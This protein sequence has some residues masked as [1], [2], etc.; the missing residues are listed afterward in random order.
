[1]K[2]GTRLYFDAD[3]NKIDAPTPAGPGTGG[4]GGGPHHPGGGNGGVDGGP[5]GN[6]GGEPTG[7]CAGTAPVKVALED[8]PA[9]ATDYL[10]TTYP[11]AV[12]KDILKITKPDCTV[13]YIVRLKDGDKPRLVVF[14]EKG[15]VVKK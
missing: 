14:D 13:N 3:G 15:G 2:D 8:L 12:V 10:K 9:A 4:N 7:A 5:G 1:L 6:G 11:D